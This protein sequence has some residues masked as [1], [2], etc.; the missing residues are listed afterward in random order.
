M[1][2]LFDE[3]FI[4]LNFLQIFNNYKKYKDSGAGCIN[5]LYDFTSSSDSG[6]DSLIDIE[7]KEY[8]LSM[9]EPI[10]VNY[11]IKIKDGYIQYSND[12]STLTFAI[13]HEFVKEID[14]LNNL[15]VPYFK[16]KYTKTN[17]QK[18]PNISINNYDFYYRNVVFNV[19]KINDEKLFIVE[20]SDSVT[21][22]YILE[23]MIFDQ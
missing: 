20:L 7:N 21:K 18:L 1:F 15:K 2:W 5:L 22:K 14:E 10:T 23:K 4:K 17:N 3:N 6:S 13:E 11:T 16:W 8:N 19:Y 9:I 12:T